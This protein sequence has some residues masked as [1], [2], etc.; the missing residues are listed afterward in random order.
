MFQYTT[1]AILVNIQSFLPL[2]LCDLVKGVYDATPA[3]FGDIFAFTY[4]NIFCTFPRF[5]VH[6]L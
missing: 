4:D 6:L 5:T 3:V 2:I 1:V